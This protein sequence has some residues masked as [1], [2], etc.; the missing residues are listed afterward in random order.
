MNTLE[1]ITHILSDED[2]RDFVAQMRRKNRRGDTKNIE[3]FRLIE[4]GTDADLDVLLYGKPSKNAYHALSKRL[5]DN[6]IDFVAT[7]SF[8]GETSEELEILKLLLASRIFFEYKQYKLG[9]KTLSKAEKKARQ[10]DLYAILTE[11]YHTKIQYAHTQANLDIKELIG[12]SQKN[13]NHFQQEQRLNMAYATIKSK[14]RSG[15]PRSINEVINDAFIDFEIALDQNLGY[16]S[17]FQLMSIAFSAAQLQSDFYQIEA[18]MEEVYEIVSQKTGPET[19]YLYYLI[20]MEHLMASTHFRNRN[21]DRSFQ[22]SERMEARMLQ[23]SRSYFNR[24]QEKLILIKALNLNYTGAPDAALTL[25]SSYPN[26][27]LD[28]SLTTIM[29]LFQQNKH[30]DAYQILKK[31]SHSDRWYEKKAGWI[32]VLK[33]NIIEILL[34]IELNRL[35]LVLARLK[36]FERRFFPRLSQENENRVIQ[37][38]KLIAYAYEHPDKIQTESFQEKVE[39]SFTW[40]QASREDVFV[41]S[42]YAWLKSK[43]EKK[44]LYSTTL[45]LVS[46]K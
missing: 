1:N 27:S 14:L 17:L 41:M 20:E 2:K 4:K 3:L 15:K 33:K 21:F 12:T 11:I 22:F 7:K 28:I 5:H 26:D 45:E 23:N 13:L 30:S 38:M 42:F 19:K 24:F 10:L 46:M 35:D 43:M 9:H 29:C 44:D 39:A 37:F 6:L 8:Q 31:L 40:K 36:S 32:W 25:L 18:F 16:K 34:L